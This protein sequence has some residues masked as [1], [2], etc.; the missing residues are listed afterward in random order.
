[1]LISVAHSNLSISFLHGVCLQLCLSLGVCEQWNRYSLNEPFL[2]IFRLQSDFGK[3]F[4]P[5]IDSTLCFPWANRQVPSPF[6]D[7][8]PGVKLA[9]H[10]L[11]CY[12]AAWHW[13]L[14]ST[15]HAQ[16]SWLRDSAH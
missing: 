12:D 1:M 8:A 11:W 3:V 16:H 7:V 5:S 15:H 4:G 2:N 10:A 14:A 6:P 13:Y 9:R